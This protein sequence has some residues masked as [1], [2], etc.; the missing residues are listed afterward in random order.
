MYVSVWSDSQLHC[1]G[2]MLIVVQVVHILLWHNYRHLAFLQH[3]TCTGWIGS[4]WLSQ[5]STMVRWSIQGIFPRNICKSLWSHK[6]L[7]AIG[8]ILNSKQKFFKY[9]LEYII[10]TLPGKKSLLSCRGVWEIN[11]CRENIIHIVSFY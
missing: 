11:I 4:P 5:I 7:C 3:C 2:L 6:H 8:P 1:G 10:L 9:V